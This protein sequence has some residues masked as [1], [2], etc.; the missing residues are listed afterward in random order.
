MAGTRSYLVIVT[1]SVRIENA[2][3]SA[4]HRLGVSIGRLTV[5]LYYRHRRRAM[6]A[7]PYT[8]L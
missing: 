6:Y 3:P 8:R 1:F 5:E 2:G 7:M 4:H